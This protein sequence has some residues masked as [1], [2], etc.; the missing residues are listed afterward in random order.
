MKGKNNR[1]DYTQDALSEIQAFMKRT[2]KIIRP[3]TVQDIL[4]ERAACKP[5]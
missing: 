1:L 2:G 4:D 5:A 3:I